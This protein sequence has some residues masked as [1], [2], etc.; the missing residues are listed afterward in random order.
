M[1]CQPRREFLGKVA[2][3]AVAL[4]LGSVGAA[5]TARSVF[6]ATVEPLKPRGPIEPRSSAP[7]PSDAWLT[8]LTGEYR[9]LFD[10]PDPASGLNLIHVFN[11]L[12]T[13]RDVHHVSHPQ[14]TAVVTL[15]NGTTMLAFNSA[16]WKKYDL[17]KLTKVTDGS[18]SPA[19]ENVFYKAPAGATS[20]SLTGAPVPIPADASMSA[21]Q[22]RGTIFLLC[23]NIFNV[24][25]GLLSHATGKPAAEL[26][27]EFL[28]NM[29]PGIELVP[30]MVVAINQAQKH[31]CT[32]MYVA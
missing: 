11:Y 14:V 15:Y 32:Y 25:M 6:A 30:A 20:L 29:V 23:N 17:G 24:W 2:A 3:G 27:A 13:Y 12:N 18:Q 22:A 19:V 26:R 21:L 5:G 8:Q 31:G 1:S 7:E 28:A 9:Q 16:M 4:G 10:T